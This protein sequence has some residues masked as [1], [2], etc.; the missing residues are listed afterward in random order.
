MIARKENMSAAATYTE[1][2]EF[3]LMEWHAWSASYRPALGAPRVAPY[4]QEATSGRQYQDSTEASCG[5]LHDNEMKSVAFCVDQ[6]TFQHQCA[7]GIEMK[8]RAAK[9]K[10][11]HHQQYPAALAAILPIMRK[12][13]LFD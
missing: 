3:L 9:Y 1:K 6:L 2:A 10:V 5:R 7:I 13:G 4:C 11:W 12:R 8:Y